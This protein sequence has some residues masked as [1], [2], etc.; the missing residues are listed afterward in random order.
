MQ[1]TLLYP[2]ALQSRNTL[3]F[4]RL[5]Y[6]LVQHISAIHLHYNHSTHTMFHKPVLHTIATHLRYPPALHTNATHTILSA[7][8]TY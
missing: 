5:C 3:C 4:I 1:H 7:C 8:A 2:P 6:I